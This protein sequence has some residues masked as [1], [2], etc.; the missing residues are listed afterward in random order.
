MNQAGPKAITR[1]VRAAALLVDYVDIQGSPEWQTEDQ[2]AAYE[3][4]AQQLRDVRALIQEA[5]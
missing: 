4:L 3:L 5:A 2:Q 1:V